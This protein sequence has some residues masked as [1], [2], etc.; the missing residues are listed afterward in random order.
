MGKRRGQE[1]DTRGRL[2]VQILERKEM[3][4]GG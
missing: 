2:K 1:V 4:G 3:G